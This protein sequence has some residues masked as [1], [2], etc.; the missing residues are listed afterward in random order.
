MVSRRD[1]PSFRYAARRRT[2]KPATNNAEPTS[3]RIQVGKPVKG[4]WPDAL[5]SGE[6]RPLPAFAAC[7]AST[8]WSVGFAAVGADAEGVA[9]ERPAV[10]GVPGVTGVVV[11]ELVLDCSVATV[12]TG[13]VSV[14]LVVVAADV[15]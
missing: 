8:L 6:T 4:N 11:C 9:F 3:A 10:V 12:V 15:V 14:L 2:P 5:R 7:V 1:Q 13:V